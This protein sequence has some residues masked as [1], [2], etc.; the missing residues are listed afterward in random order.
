MLVALAAPEDNGGRGCPWKPITFAW[1][2][3]VGPPAP[4]PQVQVN[5]VLYAGPVCQGPPGV[6]R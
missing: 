2:T 6:G 3:T 4:I 5:W 1:L